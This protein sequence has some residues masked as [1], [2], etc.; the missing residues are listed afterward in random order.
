[1]NLAET[2]SSKIQTPNKHQPSNTKSR[3]DAFAERRERS[4]AA[5]GTAIH[6]SDWSL[7]GSWIWMFGSSSWI[8]EGTVHGPFDYS[9]CS[10]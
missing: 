7:F 8:T 5:W 6:D 3:F 10:F 9:E 4:K 1:M 2:P